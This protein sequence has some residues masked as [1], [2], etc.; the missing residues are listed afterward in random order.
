MRELVTD[1]PEL[2]RLCAF[3]HGVAAVCH[4]LGIVYNLYRKQ[5]VHA[6]THAAVLVYDIVA[7]F[8]HASPAD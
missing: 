7:A 1:S 6:A 5:R 3:V 2:E 8:K 4:A